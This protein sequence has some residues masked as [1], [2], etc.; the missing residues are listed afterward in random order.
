MSRSGAHAEDGANLGD[1]HDTGGVRPAAA[2]GLVT[3][4]ELL[5][6]LGPK[7]GLRF[8]QASAL[9][10]GYGGAEANVAVSA[11]RLGARSRFV[12]RLPRNA[13]GRL[14]ERTLRG[15]GVDTT[16]WVQGGE[17]IG[18]YFAEFGVA[19]RPSRVEY[20][21]VGSGM[22]TIAPGSVP[23]GEAFSGFTWF[24]TT[25][26]TPALSSSAAAATLE[27]ADC[28]RSAGLTV[29]V[30]LNYRA[31]LWKGLAL[32]DVMSELVGLADVLFGNE[33]DL[34]NVFDITVP[35]ADQDGAP[36]EPKAYAP[37]CAEVLARFSNLKLVALTI[38]GSLSASDNLWS[39]VLGSRDGFYTTRTYHVTPIVDRIGVGDAFAAAAIFKLMKECQSYQAVLEFAVAASCLKHSVWGDFNLV[40]VQEI[41]DLADGDQRGRIVR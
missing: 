32:R 27:A 12:T 4:G 35:L 11:A 37:A 6:R 25:G 19:Q 8:E 2:T 24:H 40:E 33:E 39:G 5:V 34:K 17:R 15:L 29:S 14:G 10:L 41:E 20:D 22:A 31:T 16:Y 7:R 38:R 1:E 23:W 3:F 9:E 28:A 30:D 13:L 26:I 21:R 18:L 36:P